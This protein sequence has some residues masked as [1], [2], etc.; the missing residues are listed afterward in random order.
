ML[1]RSN[2]SGKSNLLDAIRFLRDISDP[3]GGFQRAVKLR[4]G[5]S[6]IRCLHARKQPK[7]VIELT[8]ELEGVAWTYKIE[9][10]QDNQRR[11]ILSSEVITKDGNLILERPNEDDEADP[12][13]L[14][15]TYVEQVSANK[16]FREI[17]TLLSR[18]QIGRAHV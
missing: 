5:V 1:F 8:M 17:S 2:A 13:R 16:E 12:S 4:G 3:E 15:Q 7:V 9:F 18:I 6:Q 11:A 10:G 14:S